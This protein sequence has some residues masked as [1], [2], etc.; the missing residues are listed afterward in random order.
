M[1]I[2]KYFILWYNSKNILMRNRLNKSEK[3]RKY[4]I[5]NKKFIP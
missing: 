2:D 4:K 5:K 3:I 1:I